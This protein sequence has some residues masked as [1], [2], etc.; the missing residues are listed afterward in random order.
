MK[1]LMII[2]LLFVSTVNAQSFSIVGGI[3]VANFITGGTVNDRALDAHFKILMKDDC[4]KC[5]FS[6]TEFGFGY[7]LFDK[8]NFDVYQMLFNKVYYPKINNIELVIG[9]ENIV[10]HRWKG[11]LFKEDG[12]DQYY[13]SGGGNAEIRYKISDHMSIGVQFNFRWRPENNNWVGSNWF[14]VKVEL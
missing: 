9:I 7:E 3:D 1:N 6:D 14:N 13:W 8:L 2:L 12:S 4:I 11:N 10:I 5:E